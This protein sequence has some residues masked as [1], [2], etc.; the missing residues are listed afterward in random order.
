MEVLPCDNCGFTMWDCWSVSKRNVWPPLLTTAEAPPPDKHR[1]GLQ[2]SALCNTV[3]QSI[4]GYCFYWQSPEESPSVWW[5]AAL[6]FFFFLT[7]LIALWFLHP[8]FNPT[9]T[10]TPTF[11][12]QLYLSS[13]TSVIT[14]HSLLACCFFPFNFVVIWGKYYAQPHKRVHHIQATTHPRPHRHTQPH[15][16]GKKHSLILN[17]TQSDTKRFFPLFLFWVGGLGG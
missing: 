6:V 10:F 13:C 1:R 8:P 16:R 15:T 4:S 5:S 17:P 3:A 7:S 11:I 9:P 12:F 14:T 2:G